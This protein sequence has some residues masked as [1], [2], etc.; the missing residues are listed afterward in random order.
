[1][2]Y[3][4]QIV[5][6]FLLIVPVAAAEP[7][8]QLLDCRHLANK[9]ER[10][11]CYD[12]LPLSTESQLP[13]AADETAHDARP[14]LE[15]RLQKERDSHAVPSLSFHTDQTTFCIRITARRM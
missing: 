5:V 13:P 14:A 9:T 11:R 6:L 10:L 12:A 3:T 2:R 4:S 8:V 1:M 15:Q 7:P